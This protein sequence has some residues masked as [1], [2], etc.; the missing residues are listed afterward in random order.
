MDPSVPL[1]LVLPRRWC[2]AQGIKRKECD[3]DIKTTTRCFGLA[4]SEENLTGIDEPTD[5]ATVA[6]YW[7]VAEHTSRRGA[8]G[9]T[10]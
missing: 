6:G 5:I 1:M 4:A 3:H 8:S 7:K 2:I 10:S 9:A